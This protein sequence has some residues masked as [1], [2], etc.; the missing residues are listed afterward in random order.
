MRSI[1][2]STDVFAK[3]WA[4]RAPCEDS[5]DQILR[6]VLSFTDP[7][8]PK[9]ISGQLSKGGAVGFYDSRHDVRFPEGFEVSRTYL[10][11]NYSAQAQNGVWRLQGDSRAYRS[12]NSLSRAIGA[13]TENAWINWF[14]LD[15]AGVRRPV[16]DLRKPETVA[17]RHAP[18]TMNAGEDTK[19]V[20]DES[21]KTDGEE[22][23]TWRDDVQS[24]LSRLGGRASLAHIYQEVEKARGAAR[25]SL[26]RTLEATVRKT[27]EEH[28]SDSHNYRGGPDLFFMPEGKGAGIWALRE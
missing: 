21:E 11:V 25:R 22:R 3:I 8:A 15:E 16:S 19:P 26:P 12:L 2:V 6:R 1:E 28:S 20:I 18:Q 27:L 9:T 14:Y 10:G 13:K 24:A 4:L 7:G 5:E 23:V 17:A